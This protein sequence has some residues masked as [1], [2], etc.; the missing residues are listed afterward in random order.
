[1]QFISVKQLLFSDKDTIYLNKT[2]KM[3][4]K[5]PSHNQRFQFLI[6]S[7]SE[8]YESD[9]NCASYASCGC[10]ENCGWRVV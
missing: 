1:M 2:R 8:N 9:E 3:G 5:N 7:N 10:C 4:E 6:Y